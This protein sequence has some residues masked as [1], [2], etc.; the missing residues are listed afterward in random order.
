[1]IKFLGNAEYG[2]YR[3][4]ISIVSYLGLLSLGFAGSYVKF[5]YRYKTHDN[6]EGIAKLNGLF[7]SFYIIVSLIALISGNIISENIGFFLQGKMAPS[8]I[9]L[10]SGLMKIFTLNMALTF[11]AS[12]FESYMT[13]NERFIVLRIIMLARG[14]L[15]PFL[16]VPLLILGYRSFGLGIAVTFATV[17]SLALNAYYCIKK[18]GMKFNFK[19]P[20]F[21]LFKEIA[22]FSS[23][24][25]FNIII[26]QINWNVDQF[27]I[28]KF[29]GSI[30]V[31]TYSIGAVINQLFLAT[32]TA[33]SNVFVPQVNRIVE[34]GHKENKNMNS[35][36]TSLMTRIGRVQ[37]YIL[38]LVLIGF[39]TVG[40]YFITVLW[41]DSAYTSSYYVALIL[42]VPVIVPLIQNVGI[43]IQRAKNMHAFRSLL[44]LLIAI[45]NVIISIPLAKK[46][47][48]IGAAIGTAIGLTIG[49][50]FIMNWYYHAKVGLDMSFFWKN[51]LQAT[52]G[53]LPAALLSF[54][55]LKTETENLSTFILKSAAILVVYIFFV[56]HFSFN[57]YEK[58][59]LKK[60]E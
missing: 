28:G 19:K 30:A 17:S 23:F 5:Y 26:D 44:Y 57:E 43:E 12:L 59:L 3:L 29:V 35:E 11:P 20:D 32:S 60:G 52:K 10:S 56:W 41:L 6:E 24:L 25:F 16:G 55:F 47:G 13:A 1:M 53:M 27:I 51:I 4:S 31:A 45:F 34:K 15:N 8:E 38:M 37:Y 48:D 40:H 54:L 22:I 9:S 50:V 21:L 39:I 2:V 7:M 49:N 36:L 42:V 14:V 58:K 33:V 46:H 18:I